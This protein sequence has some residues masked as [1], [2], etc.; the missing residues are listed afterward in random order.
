[1]VVIIVGWD[2]HLHVY[3]RDLVRKETNFL[4]EINS[5]GGSSTPIRIASAG[6]FLSTV[7]V[8]MPNALP[9]KD[10]EKM[11]HEIGALITDIQTLGDYG[12]AKWKRN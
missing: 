3:L 4:L 8:N 10:A 7:A 2:I 5:R 12:I 1:M 6:G 11:L 9:G